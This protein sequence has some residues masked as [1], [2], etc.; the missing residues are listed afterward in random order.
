MFQHSYF[1][2]VGHFGSN[3]IFMWNQCNYFQTATQCGF[4]VSKRDMASHLRMGKGG[5]RQDLQRIND[6]MMG[7]GSRDKIDMLDELVESKVLKINVNKKDA[8]TRNEGG[9]QLT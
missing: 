2:V 7:G 9:E 1:R 6:K 8:A 4:R 3:Y 5:L